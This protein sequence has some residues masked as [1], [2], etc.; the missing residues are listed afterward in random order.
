MTSPVSVGGDTMAGM[1][2]TP[3]RTARRL[4]RGEASEAVGHLGWRF[5]LGVLRT[6][7]AVT[8]LGQA[9]EAATRATAAAG[10]NAGDHLRADARP[11]RLILSLQTASS[12]SVT[13][14][15]TRLAARVSAALRELGLRT[16]PETN[17]GDE[18]GSGRSVQL[19]EIAI[20]ALDVATVRPFWKEVLGYADEAGADGPTDPLVDPLGQHPAVWFQHMDAARPQ[21]NR[22][23]LDISVP[24]DEARRR[25][26]AAL[27]AGGTLVSDQFAPA[28]W[29]LADPEGNEA[30]VTTWQGRD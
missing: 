3:D 5:V 23:H 4:S 1:N 9:L 30:C 7:V 8:S 28:F 21:R 16:S 2:D 6:H 15:D 10:D 25:V 12:A 26:D 18:P 11:H 24:H 22:I 27:A 19:L 13:T 14:V 29:V 17:T 20:D